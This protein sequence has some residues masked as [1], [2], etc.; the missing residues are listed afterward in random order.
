M[1]HRKQRLHPLYIF[2]EFATT[3]RNFSVAIIYFIVL[4]FNVDSGFYIFM[5]YFL[6]IYLILN[7]IYIIIR[8]LTTSYILN[9]DYIQMNFG[10]ISRQ[11][12]NIPLIQ[13]QNIQ[14]QTTA[15]LRPFNVTSVI[16]ETG[17]VNKNASIKLNVISK[18]QADLITNTIGR[19]QSGTPIE[20]NKLERMDNENLQTKRTVHFTTTKK[21]IIKASFTSLQFLVLIPIL[22]SMYFRVNELY[23]IEAQVD[24][25]I[26]NL[27][28]SWIF[29]IISAS[30]LVIVS[31]IFGIVMTYFKYGKFIVSSDSKH[32]FI[33]KGVFNEKVFT[34]KKHHVQAIK[35]EQS[36][37]KRLLGIAEVKLVTAG[38]IDKEENTFS[39]LYPYLPIQKAYL[40]IQELTPN[41]T[42]VH[43]M[44]RLPKTALWMNLLRIPWFGI[45]FTILLFIL[46]IDLWWSAV[47]F[48]LAYGGRFLQYL[49]TGYIINGEILQ[50][51][52]GTFSKNVFIT[53][54]EK[55]IEVRLKRSWLQKQFKIAT[56][57]TVNR[58]KPVHHEM[59]EDIPW[60][61]GESFIKWF[62]KRPVKI[63]K[64][65][66]K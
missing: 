22:V 10:I 40:L 20:I 47:I 54:R 49:N 2:L 51:K 60:K 50:F 38:E 39:S 48:I 25:W 58:S 17:S 4:K 7:F 15:V 31:I 19:S 34:I 13:I 33:Q 16:L 3:L 57:K 65:N 14:Q 1:R 36:L 53:R 46:N 30:L 55:I 12:R 43:T 64:S 45:I 29:I 23:N 24:H 66:S 42:V 6:Y 61:F 63:V 56:L 5:R 9:E 26:A 37:I 32:I 41:F 44:E 18:Q 62:E 27:L 11:R 28:M 21:D 52:S 35:I 59:I 8:W